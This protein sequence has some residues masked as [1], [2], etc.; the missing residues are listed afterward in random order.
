MQKT[1]NAIETRALTKVYKRQFWRKPR[2]TLDGLEIE[3][4]RREIY[5]FLG[6]NGAG[7]TTTIKILCGLMRPTSGTARIAGVDVRER[8]A[9]THIGYL[10]ENPYFYEYLTPKETIEFYARLKGLD[11][12]ERAREWDRLSEDLDLRDI[13]HQRVRGFSK[14]MRQRLGF[15]VALVGNPP[16]L[17]LDE[18][19]S[20]LD[21]MGRRRIRD[22]IL[23]QRDT[24]K[25]IFFS[26]HVLSDVELIS[27]RVGLL[28][29]GRLKRQGVMD[30][31]L[32]T[33][34][35][36]VE[37]VA[38]NVPD[39]I[40]GGLAA[41]AY[42]SRCSEQGHHFAFRDLDTA[43]DAARTIQIHGGTLLE[44]SPMKE[45]LEDYFVREQ[46]EVEVGA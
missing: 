14:G 15:A 29:N 27:D 43:N 10:P 9:R 26:S 18:P 6:K 30:D 7:K 44:F 8:Q 42:R 31:L 19:M 25:T 45:T 4:R 23:A 40:A 24:G 46:A 38:R 39:H 20:G 37:I 1:A 13:A 41:N 11:A 12:A 22:L 32:A 36:L 5:G 2:P 33:R 35:S 28:V 3:V 16:I 34:I 17:I 21:P